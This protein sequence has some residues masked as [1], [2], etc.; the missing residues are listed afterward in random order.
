[1]KLT[2]A[3]PEYAELLTD[4]KNRIA[5]ARVSAARTVNREMILLYWDRSKGIM[6]K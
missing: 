2:P 6:E 1:M 5:G 4:L 3:N